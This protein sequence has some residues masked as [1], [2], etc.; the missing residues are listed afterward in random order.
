MGER[1]MG[2]LVLKDEMLA[3][4]LHET[5]KSSAIFGYFRIT[6]VPRRPPAAW[7]EPQYLF[8]VGDVV[9]AIESELTKWPL[10]SDLVLMPISAVVYKF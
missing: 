4:R 8:E 1:D 10:P 5:G 2:T 3:E 7:C 6:E 9:L